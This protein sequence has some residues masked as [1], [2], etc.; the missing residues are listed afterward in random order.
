MKPSR[1][2]NKYKRLF[3]FYLIGLIVGLASLCL[4]V[5]PFSIIIILLTSF[6]LGSISDR[7]FFDNYISKAEQA[8]GNYPRYYGEAGDNKCQ[9]P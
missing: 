1:N 8:W 9:S 2:K 4:D 5:L 6:G 7:L 3:W